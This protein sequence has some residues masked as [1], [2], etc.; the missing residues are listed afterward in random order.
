MTSA[1]MEEEEEVEEEVCTE[2]EEVLLQVDLA[3]QEEEGVKTSGCYKPKTWKTIS[4]KSL[5]IS[6]RSF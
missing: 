4:E 2:E 3:P 5:F 6:V 1:V